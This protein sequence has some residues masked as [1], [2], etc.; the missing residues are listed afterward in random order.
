MRAFAERS[1]LVD[2][3]FVSFLGTFVGWLAWSSRP[4]LERLRAILNSR[5]RVMVVGTYQQM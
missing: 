4:E 1:G 5:T 2:A 3:E